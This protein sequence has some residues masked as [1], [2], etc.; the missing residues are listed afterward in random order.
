MGNDFPELSLLTNAKL[1]LE[2]LSPT[3]GT[4]SSLNQGNGPTV[5]ILLLAPSTPKKE[6]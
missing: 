2:T 3:P 4:F 1:G 6:A 5:Y